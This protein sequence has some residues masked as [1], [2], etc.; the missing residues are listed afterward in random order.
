MAPKPTV[1]TDLHHRMSAMSKSTSKSELPHV[2]KMEATGHLQ[3]RM[4]E[5]VPLHHTLGIWMS[6]LTHELP[7]LHQR[8]IM[9]M[10]QTDHLLPMLA[11]TLHL[12]H[13]RN[14][15]MMSWVWK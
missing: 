11:T 12:L 7:H 10:G 4:V 9:Q 1:A 13:T 15:L 6:S 3:L 8:E 5:I 2:L 14:V